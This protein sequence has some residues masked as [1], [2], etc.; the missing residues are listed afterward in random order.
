M[1]NEILWNK[2]LE[3]TNIAIKLDSIK[4]F[5]T[6]LDIIKENCINYELRSLIGKPRTQSFNLGPK[7]NP[8]CPWELNL[9]IQKINN[10]H[11]L[12][13]NKYPVEIGHMLLI[14]NR[15]YPQDGWLNI[16]D[17]KALTEVEKDTNGL[18]FFN[19]SPNA[20]ASQPHRHLQLLRRTHT[21]NMFPRQGWFEKYINNPNDKSISL[22]KSCM[23]LRRKKL[24]CPYELDDL[25]KCL[26]IQ[27]KLGSKEVYSKPLTSYNLLIT[28]E[29]ISLITRKFES[30]RGFN[31][32][33]LGFAG[34]ILI[35]KKSDVK[36]LLN[37]N[38]ENLLEAVVLGD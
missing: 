2:A 34:Y 5:K 29:W 30:Y 21:N 17:W 28:S 23:T 13:L 15:W 31:I 38:C 18:W 27:M 10:S 14:T 33:A 3:K 9:E 24:F 1:N 32:N 36:W 19:N 25:Y 7:L 20:G 8:F 11:V 16:D 35:T 26:C 4:P 37:N 22:Y 12:I 6:R